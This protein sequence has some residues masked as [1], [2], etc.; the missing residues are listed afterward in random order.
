M[1][2]RSS[3]TQHC[4]TSTSS[5]YASPCKR[6]STLVSFVRLLPS[7]PPPPHTIPEASNSRLE[8]A[9]FG[10]PASHVSAQFSLHCPAPVF[11]YR[12]AH[13]TPSFIARFQS[14][15]FETITTTQ[16]CVRRPASCKKCLK[17]SM[18]QTLGIPH[19]TPTNS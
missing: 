1:L 14:L 7:E 8:H 3:E 11:F 18:T 19:E 17:S 5:P 13:G 16:S 12:D 15:D 10:R 4:P 6:S 9:P 2:L